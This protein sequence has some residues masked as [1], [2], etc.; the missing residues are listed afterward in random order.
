MSVASA[1]LQAG[2][3]RAAAKEVPIFARGARRILRNFRT[4]RRKGTYSRGVLRTPSEGVAAGSA[5]PYTRSRLVGEANHGVVTSTDEISAGFASGLSVGQNAIPAIDGTEGRGGLCHRPCPILAPKANGGSVGG[6]LGTWGAFRLGR[7][8]GVPRRRPRLPD[9]FLAPNHR[10]ESSRVAPNGRR[11]LHRVGDEL[12]DVH[13]DAFDE[14][15]CILE[16]VADQVGNREAAPRPLTL[17]G[18]FEILRHSS[19]DEPILALAT[20]SGMG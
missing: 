4:A 19:L 11:Q 9:L 6:I 14:V 17:Q 5:E 12:L 7:S 1:L 15:E 13:R 2:C 3:Q 8:L 10:R 20:T 18:L 16:G